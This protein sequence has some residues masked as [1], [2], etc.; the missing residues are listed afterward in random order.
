MAMRPKKVTKEAYQNAPQPR[1]SSRNQGKKVNYAQLDNPGE[2]APVKQKK[3]RYVN[4]KRLP[5]PKNPIALEAHKLDDDPNY[6]GNLDVLKIDPYD[7]YGRT[8]MNV[9]DHDS[10]LY[11]AGKRIRYKVITKQPDEYDEEGNK[12]QHPPEPL[13]LDDVVHFIDHLS[14]T[15]KKEGRNREY[16]V[17]VYGGDGRYISSK[18]FRSGYGLSLL[19]LLGPDG[20]E[21]YGVILQDIVA[22]DVYYSDIGKVK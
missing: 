11:N 21:A 4:P 1:T 19:G 12:V 15:D 3:G 6:R 20:D 14:Y 18:A 10:P 13:Q 5:K 7:K 8:R 2:Y 22:V 16:R 9:S 17:T